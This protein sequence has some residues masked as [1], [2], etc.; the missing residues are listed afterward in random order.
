MRGMWLFG[1]RVVI[2]LSSGCAGSGA[3]QSGDGSSS[4]G[5]ASGGP[6]VTG[7]DGSGGGGGS[8]APTGGVEATGGAS[9]TEG[10]PTSSGSDAETGADPTGGDGGGLGAAE[11][12]DGELDAPSHGGTITFQQIGAAGWYPSRRDPELGPCDAY[13]A[14]GCCLA[15]HEVAGEQLTPW[16]EDLIM[17]LRGPLQIKQFAAYRPEVGGAW[18]LV[19]SWDE[20]WP[21][22][23]EGLAF[24]GNDSENGGFAGVVG[25]EC[26]VDVST[27]REFACG[28]GSVPFCPASDE[29]RYEGWA[30]SKLFVLLARMP[31]ADSGLIGA[32]CSDNMNGNWYD[33]PWIGLSHGE[34]VRAGAFSGCQCYAKNPEEWYLGD[35]CGQFNVFEVVNDN[36]DFQNFG[37]FST[38]F[39][40][41]GGYVGEGPCGGGCDV[42]KL[43]PEVDLIDKGE[44]VEAGQGAV[45]TPGQGPGAA[46]R[47][48]VE[49]YRYF[50]VL[51][52][53]NTRTV[54]LA[55]VHPQQV[56]GEL[57]PLLPNLPAKV[58][59]AAITDALALRL[60]E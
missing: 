44:N 59:Q 38:N 51:M 55:V 45:A 28:A 47:R 13:E 25:T 37:V 43:G 24:T 19:S 40:G 34:L 50:I 46:F 42:S 5:G 17:T 32:P 54:Q 18:S 57:A 12:E 21:A 20:R 4:T 60:P 22:E 8:T 9:A 56:P 6:A 1:A 33:A 35:G 49:G 11:F 41:Y 14:D 23:G 48:P 3:P 26:L 7:E 27:D 2:V 29:P 16:D 39:F 58:S 52:D 53:T 15:K 30:G 10:G 31:H 36:N